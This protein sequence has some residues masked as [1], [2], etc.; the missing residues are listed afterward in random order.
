MKSPRWDARVVVVSLLL[1]F[2]ALPHTLED[3]ATGEPAKAGAPIYL[4]VYLI[5]GL[6]AAQGLGLWWIGCQMRRGYVIQAILGLFWPVAAGAA[7]LPKVL[8]QGVSYRAGFIS[9][10]LVA[11]M[12]AVG[13]LLL[14]VSMLAL[15]AGR[16]GLPRD[17]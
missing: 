14:I 8:R 4:L 17:A 15:R 5:A 10:F 7:Q 11:G 16:S 12:I 13:I 2:F 3:F 9:V 6:F 1:I